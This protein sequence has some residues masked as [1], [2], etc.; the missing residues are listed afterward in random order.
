M[1]EVLVSLIVI[2]ASVYLFRRFRST[3]GGNGGQGCDKCGW[4]A[5]L[6]SLTV[7]IHW[8]PR[9]NMMSCINY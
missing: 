7:I 3:S 9:M 1:Q 6:F 2:A 8:F 5:V 4:A